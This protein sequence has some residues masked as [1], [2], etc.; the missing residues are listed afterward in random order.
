MKRRQIQD[1]TSHKK[2][3]QRRKEQESTCGRSEDRLS[4]DLGEKPKKFKLQI[5]RQKNERSTNP[6]GPKWKES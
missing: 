5:D 2:I 4:M 1:S 6:E 3:N